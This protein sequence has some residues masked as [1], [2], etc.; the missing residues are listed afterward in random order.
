[1]DGSLSTCL[2]QFP[3]L[4][5]SFE[6]ACMRHAGGM[7]SRAPFGALVDDTASFVADA[8]AAGR[9]VVLVGES[10]GATLALGVALRLEEART[11]V[12]GVV[13]INPATSYPRSALARLGPP[14]AAL[15]QPLF[16][17]GLPLLALLVFDL[18]TQLPA[19]ISL[20]RSTRLPALLSSP[21]REA[22]LGR[23][24]LSAFLGRRG[25]NLDIGPLLALEIF[26]PDDLAFRLSS[27][28]DEGAATV[29]PRLSELDAPTL[30]VVGGRDRLLP[31]VDEAGRLGRRLGELRGTV[32]VPG[33]GHGSTLGP[34]LNLSAAIF[35]AFG[36]ELRDTDA[37]ARAGSGARADSGGMGGA[38]GA[39]GASS[40]PGSAR[41]GEALCE[42]APGAAD[43]ERGL[44]PRPFAPLGIGDYVRY[45]RGGDLCPGDA[46]AAAAG[47]PPG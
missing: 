13:L 32:R 12:A 30:C 25:R 36:E 20:L 39:G 24:A 34:A 19:F 27:W 11:R 47:A 9:R 8:C 14:L 16:L 4:G 35:G 44:L 38:D 33:A 22:Y 26:A 31:S 2:F 17:L 43:W 3:E 7:G 18:P 37:G 46:R 41:L 5:A 40:A 42:L 1:M 6:L 15:P 23:V 28:L 45:N 21:A 10:F 29:E